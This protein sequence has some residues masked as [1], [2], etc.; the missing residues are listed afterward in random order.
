MATITGLKVS[1]L[2]NLALGS[3]GTLFYAASASANSFKMSEQSLYNTLYA[4]HLSGVFSP[5]SEDWRFVHKTGTESITGTKTFV[6]VLNS[7]GGLNTTTIQ[8]SSLSSFQNVLINQN[9][10]IFGN[11]ACPEPQFFSNS[12]YV[13]GFSFIIDSGGLRVI[14]ISEKILSGD[15]QSRQFRSSQFI[16]S[17]NAPSTPTS[18]GVSGQLAISGQKLFIAT[19][20]NQWGYLNITPWI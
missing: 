10:E 5:K 13:S 20:T 1:E 9:L 17:G 19:G 18:A 14:D 15:W 3:T 8:A 2:S 12:R 11:I 4:L 7:L 6:A 16:L